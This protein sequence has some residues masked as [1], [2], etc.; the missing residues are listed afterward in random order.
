MSIEEEFCSYVAETVSLI[1]ERLEEKYGGISLRDES[2]W[3]SVLALSSSALGQ[4]T[5]LLEAGR[6]P[7]GVVANIADIVVSTV[8]LAYQVGVGL[9]GSDGAG[10]AE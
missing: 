2:D 5:D 7:E 10:A 1:V 4:I 3:V 6:D 9:G 8:K